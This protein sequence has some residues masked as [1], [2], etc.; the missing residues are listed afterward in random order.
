[1]SQYPYQQGSPGYPPPVQQFIVAPPPTNGLGVAGFVTSLIGVVTCGFLSPIGLLFSLVGLTRR[2]RG[3]AIAG[4]VLGALG[5]LWLFVAG[6]AMVMGLLGL[7][8]AAQTV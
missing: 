6:F 2:P 8:R 7:S 4:T 5:S 3:L 1:M